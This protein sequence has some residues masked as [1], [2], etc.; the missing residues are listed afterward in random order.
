M[1]TQ[2]WETKEQAEEEE[3]LKQVEKEQLVGKGVTESS[4][5]S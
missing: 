5:V 4:H 1:E 3:S 2:I